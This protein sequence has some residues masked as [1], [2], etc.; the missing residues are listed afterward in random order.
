MLNRRDLLLASI[1]AGVAVQ[2]RSAFAKASQP[3]TPVNFEMPPG[4]CDCHTHI[5]LPEKYPFFDGARLHAG[6]R[7]AAGNGRAA[8]GAPH[9]ARRD[10]DAQRLRH[11]QFG[12]ARGHASSAAI[13]RAASP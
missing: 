11:R 3:T 9:R 5:H 12:D 2:N 7:N 4:A 13:R 1:A 10:R 8:Q 6:A